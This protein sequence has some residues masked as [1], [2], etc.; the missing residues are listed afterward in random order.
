[1]N[2]IER[3]RAALH[4]EEPDRIPVYNISSNYVE[5]LVRSDV[6]PMLLS[7]SKEFNPGWTEEEI[8][9]YPKADDPFFRWK[10]PPWTK[11]AKYVEMR[12]NTY[13]MLDEWGCIWEN[14]AK[15][16]TMG[17]PSRPS[18]LD[19]K[20]L[21][22][23]VQR[24]FPHPNDLHR[25]RLF[26]RLGRI[27]GRKKYRMG[28][29][30]MGPLGIAANMRGFA[31]FM[32]DHR[33]NP[34]QVR[35]LLDFIV[36]NIVQ[37]MKK[38]KQTSDVHGFMLFDDLGEQDRPFMSVKMFDAFY[39]EVYARLYTAA[40]DLG[41]EFHHHACGKVD[42]LIP[43]LIRGGVDAM[44]FDSPR[45][46]GYPNLQPFRG[47]IMFW[48]CVNIQSIYPQGS[49][50]EVTREVWHMMR[51]MGTS[52]GGFGAYFYREWNDIEVP[53]PNIKAYKAGLK[54]FGTYAKI[55]QSWWDAPLPELWKDDE[56]P[57]VPPWDPKNS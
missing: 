30:S 18:L 27:F 49:V 41:C 45:M 39:E 35:K 24:Y 28:L 19:W 5:M 15:V 53:K 57:P 21:E 13:K 2:S 47:Q 3:V 11:E 52:K 31:N 34:T 22:R 42:S 56:V 20:N 40:Q 26:N 36:E 16:N 46:T 1:M 43:T 14:S 12:R 4:F 17:H 6:F 9:L 23:Y 38:W 48:G 7:P 10:R 51:N 55:P 32:G 33:K 54:Q 8:G 44:E 50:D 37:T 25:Y 29:F